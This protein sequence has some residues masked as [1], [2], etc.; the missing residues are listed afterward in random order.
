[1]TKNTCL[2]GWIDHIIRQGGFPENCNFFYNHFNP[3]ALIMEIN[4]EKLLVLFE[5]GSFKIKND[6][7]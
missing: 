1:M 6:K 7:I 4:N 2:N 3:S 5:H